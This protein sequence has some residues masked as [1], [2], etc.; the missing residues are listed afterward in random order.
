MGKRGPKTAASKSATQVAARPGEQPPWEKEGLTRAEKVI[1]FIETLPITSGAHAGRRF[2]LR[3]WQKKIIKALYKTNKAGKRLVRQGL[4]TVG[5]KNGKTQLAAALALNHL[6]GSEVEPRGQIFSAASDREQASLIFKELE[7]FIYAI[8]EFSER[9]HIQSFHR[10][11]TDTVSGSVYK[12]VTSDGRKAHG[13]SPSF[14]I[15]DELAMWHSR[16]LFDNL[17]TGTGARSEPLMI[18]IGTQSADSNHI[19]SEL[20][21]YAEKIA[22]GTL[23]RDK[24]FSGHVFTVPIDADPWDEKN[25]KLANPALGDFRSLEEMRN[26]GEQAQKIPAKEA[27]FRN[28]YLNQRVDPSGRWISSESFGSCVSDIPDLTGRACYAGLDLSSTQDL[29]ALSLCFAPI[30]EGEPYYVLSFAWCP[31]EAIKTRSTRDR[32]D[33]QLWAKHGYLEATPGAVVDYGYILKRIEEL[34]KKFNLKAISYDRWGS[35]KIVKDIEDMGL[36]VLEFGQ[37]F[38]SMSPPAKE[39]E[40]LIL[41]KKI[42]FQDNPALR[43]C[44]G[45][46]QVEIDSAGNIKPSKKRSKEKIDM[47]VS[48]IMALDGALRNTKKSVVPS[49]TWL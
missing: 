44:F 7:A 36:A 6:L 10:T 33:Y 49:I 4:I 28:L 25:W 3:P 12:A 46:V 11:I 17:L 37:G 45:N 35:T 15:A 47:V 20:V 14:I 2:I 9:C 34:G 27:V 19:M 24:T 32:V 8:P 29:S 38:A 41:E 30:A 5:R 48:T 31:K 40:K 23:P 21:D 1:A 22:D 42:V 13:L 39:L 26:F 43:W 18:T 16:D